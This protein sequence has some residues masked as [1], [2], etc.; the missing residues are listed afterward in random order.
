VTVDTS[1]LQMEVINFYHLM[2]SMKVLVPIRMNQYIKYICLITIPISCGNGARLIGTKLIRPGSFLGY[3][4][5]VSSSL[6]NW[7]FH[8]LQREEISPEV[9]PRQK[10]REEQ[11]EYLGGFP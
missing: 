4:Q 3:Q 6:E 2:E 10:D 1:R 11:G 5:K 7:N 8:L 9:Q